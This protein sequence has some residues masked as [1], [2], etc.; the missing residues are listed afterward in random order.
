MS[1]LDFA[2]IL[3][4]RTVLKAILRK[5][6][7]NLQRN[8][9]VDDQTKCVIEPVLLSLQNRDNIHPCEIMHGRC[10]LAWVLLAVV[11]IPEIT[12]FTA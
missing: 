8:P 4:V 12:G 6:R 10:I 5:Q 2:A 9:L 1:C 7:D 11:G 3:L